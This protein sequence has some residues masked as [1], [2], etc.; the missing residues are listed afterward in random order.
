[1]AGTNRKKFLRKLI[2]LLFR[3]VPKC[4]KIIFWLTNF[5]I[6]EIAWEPD[7]SGSEILRRYQ[8]FPVVRAWV[9]D[10]K[11]V[12][13]GSET[14]AAIYFR[15]F[16]NVGVSANRRGGFIITSEQIVVP[17]NGL[18]GLP[19]LHYPNTDVAG[20]IAQSREKILWDPLPVQYK[21]DC[22]VF[23]GSIAPH[24]WF[25]WIIDTLPTVFLA[26][27][28][29][30]NYDDFPLLIPSSAM[31]KDNWLSALKLVAGNREIVPI[32]P[33]NITHVKKLIRIDS[34]TRPNPRPLEAQVRA[35]I[36]ALSVP[37]LEY[38]DFV[39]RSLGLLDV[40]SQPDKKIFIAR[41]PGSSRTYN[42]EEII[43]ETAKF[44]FQPVYLESL[45]FAES[46]RVFREASEIIGPHGAGWANLIFSRPGV[47]A[48][49]WTWEG[50]DQDN[51]YENIAHISRVNFWQ[52]RVPVEVGSSRDPRTAGYE[53]DFSL[54]EKAL[55]GEH[56]LS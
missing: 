28:L 14:R 41:R 3:R 15:V 36:S 7:V 55:S 12:N 47:K 51:W 52:I 49:M 38:Q 1:M 27:Y 21:L 16:E 53:L 44:G 18:P 4:H 19:K 56:S 54:I 2:A 25:H 40:P 46:I 42:Q 37:L 17:S 10:G 35:R 43:T 45:S 39:L 32:D 33:E 48:V 24:N 29:P 20:I 9:E 50:E 22:G 23:V 5:R 8:T 26:R 30:P 6:L 31:G 34:V 13:L 11:L